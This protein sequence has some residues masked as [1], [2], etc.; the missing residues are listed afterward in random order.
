MI[1]LATEPGL[2]ANPITEPSASDH[3]PIET[4]DWPDPPESPIDPDVPRLFWRGIVA[5]WPL[6][7]RQQWGDRANQLQ[8]QGLD[9]KMAELRAFEEQFSR[10]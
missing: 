3:R 5:H 10:T 8:D 2:L 7:S 1:C 6:K 4:F 9:W